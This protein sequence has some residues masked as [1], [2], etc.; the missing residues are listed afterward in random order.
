MLKGMYAKQPC[1]C[2]VF[3]LSSSLFAVSVEL[4]PLINRRTFSL[5]TKSDIMNASLVA[6]YHIPLYFSSEGVLTKS[7][8]HLLPVEQHHH[9]AQ[10]SW[11]ILSPLYGSAGCMLLF[12]C[13]VWFC[14]TALSMADI[15]MAR[16]FFAQGMRPANHRLDML[17]HRL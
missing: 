11:F 2:D 12:C 10:C 1:A 5:D 17:C 4:Y 7:H 16:S 15:C 8:I 6:F 3:Q 9:A 14:P 13:A